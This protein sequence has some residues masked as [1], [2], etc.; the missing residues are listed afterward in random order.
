MSLNRNKCKQLLISRRKDSRI[1]PYSG[2]DVVS[3]V[4]ILGVTLRSDLR[5]CEHFSRTLLSASRRLHILRFLRPIVTKERLLHVYCSSV[6]SV[7]LYAAPVFGILPTT[8]LKR[9]RTLQRRAHRIICSPKCT[10]SLLP[11]FCP[12]KNK[13]ACDLFLKCEFPE[14]PLH[15]LAPLRMP[16]SR[17]F[18]LP[19]C[20]TSRRLRSFFPHTCLLV[21]SDCV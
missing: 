18:R 21:N 16:S 2:I 3:S 4:N 14:H 11:D 8:I 20:S 15:L 7:L 19:P 6:L 5:W 12:L 17:R 1:V 13:L 10:C 9:L